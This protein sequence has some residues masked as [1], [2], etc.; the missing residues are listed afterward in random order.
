MSPWCVPPVP[1]YCTEGMWGPYCFKRAGARWARWILPWERKSAA[2]N[3]L[4][5]PWRPLNSVQCSTNAVGCSRITMTLGQQYFP[6]YTLWDIGPT[7]WS[8]TQKRLR[9]AHVLEIHTAHYHLQEPENTR[10]VLWHWFSQTSLVA[11]PFDGESIF[12]SEWACRKC[13][14][15]VADWPWLFLG[16]LFSSWRINHIN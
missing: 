6:K 10:R 11:G 13:C 2:A 12:P 4:P 7:R 15:G 3:V 9:Q 1:V 14:P 16:C 8:F 5:L